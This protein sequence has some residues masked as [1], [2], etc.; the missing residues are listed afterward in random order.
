MGYRVI[1]TKRFNKDI[2]TCIKR[3]NNISLLSEIIDNY[4]LKDI[5]IPEKYYDHSLKG[6]YI[7]KRECH[8]QPDWL[9][10][11]EIDCDNLIIYLVRTGTHSDIFC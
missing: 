9:L 2:K 11:Y 6:D 8:I 3:N 7:G 5:S 4:L 1:K 10:I